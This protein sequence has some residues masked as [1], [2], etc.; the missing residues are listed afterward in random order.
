MGWGLAGTGNSSAAVVAAAA[1]VAP[2]GGGKE[3]FFQ[4]KKPP[5]AACWPDTGLLMKKGIMFHEKKTPEAACWPDA[6]LLKGNVL[7]ATSSRQ[8]PHG[9]VPRQPFLIQ[10]HRNS[11]TPIG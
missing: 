1:V 6:G 3:V 11:L 9:N 2:Q 8:R 5:E 4:E 10:N 7:V